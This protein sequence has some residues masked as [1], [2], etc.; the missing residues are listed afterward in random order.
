MSLSSVCALNFC[1][2][3]PRQDRSTVS[4]HTAKNCVLDFVVFECL[5]V[6]C[7]C[8][9]VVLLSLVE[10]FVFELV[11]SMCIFCLTIKCLLIS[12]LVFDLSTNFLFR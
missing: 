10:V 4:D 9:Y 11:G 8:S 3:R 2:F 1:I 6:Y 7:L 5:Q 12:V